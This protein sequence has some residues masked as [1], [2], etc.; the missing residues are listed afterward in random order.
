MYIVKLLGGGEAARRL[1]ENIC[2]TR[3]DWGGYEEF[4]TV[5]EGSR[6]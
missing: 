2:S 1:A 3:I 5:H 4:E 6:I